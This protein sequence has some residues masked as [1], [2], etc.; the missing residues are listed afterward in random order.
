M[1]SSVQ[2]TKYGLSTALMNTDRCANLR[3]NI[4]MLTKSI[5]IVL[6][7]VLAIFQ[8]LRWSCWTISSTCGKAI[9]ERG[10]K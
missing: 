2:I 4:R 1:F 5:L 6:N 7:D 8:T 9:G 3:R 10:S